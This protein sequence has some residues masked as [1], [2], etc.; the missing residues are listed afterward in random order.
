MK[1]QLLMV[2]YH[3]PK[4]QLHSQFSNVIPELDFSQNEKMCHVHFMDGCHKLC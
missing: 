1:Q 3:T 2:S 4:A